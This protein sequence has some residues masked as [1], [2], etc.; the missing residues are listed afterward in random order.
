LRVGFVNLIT[1][2][3]DLPKVALP[4]M[5]TGSLSP[6]SDQDLNVVEMSRSIA[7]L[8]HEVDLYISDVFLPKTRWTP[9]QRMRIEYIPTR[10]KRAFPPTLAPLTPSLSGIV[11][12]MKYD[13]MITTELFQVGTMLTWLAA[14]GTST[15]TFVWQ[16]LDILMRGPAGYAQHLFYRSMGR[17]VAHDLSLIVPRSKSARRHLLSEG[18]PEDSIG[19]TV[20]HSGVDTDLFR[21]MDQASC[22]RRHGLDEA[23]S[24]IL[25]LGRL[26]VNKGMDIVI[27][28]MPAILKE[29]PKTVLVIKGIGPQEPELRALA[30]GLGLGDS[31]RFLTEHISKEEMPALFNCANLL[32]VTSRIDLFPFT[33][34]ESISCGVPVATSFERGLRTDMVD[35]GAA[36]LLP[37]DEQRLP[38]ALS[39]LLADSAK[40]KEMGRRGRMLAEADFDFKVGAQRF[41]R[42]FAGEIT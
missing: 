6:P 11:R 30:T 27:N 9:G 15:R 22:R 3:G 28:A 5:D 34:I 33:S 13:A 36:A 26:H 12:R 20:V 10:M 23:E 2:T 8:G 41:A 14:K 7:E 19:R 42:I 40:L 35:E 4:T 29:R 37:A 18:I 1:K 32:A 16:E 38:D 17:K 25:C 21:P 24:V 31:V 39:G